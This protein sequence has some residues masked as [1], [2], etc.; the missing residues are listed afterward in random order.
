MRM[1]GV[2]RY[3]RDDKCFFVQIWRSLIR[4]SVAFHSAAIIV[5]I[6][7]FYKLKLSVWTGVDAIDFCDFSFEYK[8]S[9]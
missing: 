3:V 7:L 5:Y 8:F 2:L 9:L 6:I 1:A 4:F